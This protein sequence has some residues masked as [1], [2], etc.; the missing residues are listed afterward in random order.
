VEPTHRTGFD[1]SSSGQPTFERQKQTGPSNKMKKI[2]KF[3]KR[4]WYVFVVV[5]II[6][7]VLIAWGVASAR[8]DAAWRRANDAFGKADYETAKKEIEGYGVPKEQDR[9][10]V[11]AQTMLATRT[12]DKALTGYENLYAVNKDQGTLLILGNIYNQKGDYDKAITTY[13]QIISNNPGNLQA[14]VNLATVYKLKS[15]QDKAIAT[16]K[17]AVEKNPKSAIA[18]ELLV[19]M[20]L[21]DKNSED[22]KKA[23][24]QLKAINPEDP[25]LQAINA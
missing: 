24:E 1:S 23:V 14:Y 15:E 2:L 13:K 12:L 22:Y 11:Y 18:L 8:E 20:L 9:L 3:V 21:E 17:E 25:L 10:K 19:S 6:A 4:F 5:A 16:A 7:G